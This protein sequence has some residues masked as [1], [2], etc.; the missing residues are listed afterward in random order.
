MTFGA[1]VLKEETR[2]IKA[3]FVARQI[4]GARNH[5]AVHIVFEAI[6]FVEMNR[7]LRPIIENRFFV[8]EAMLF[9]EFLSFLIAND[10][11]L[12]LVIAFDDRFHLMIDAEEHCGGGGASRRQQMDADA[13]RDVIGK[14]DFHIWI[15][16]SESHREDVTEGGLVYFHRVSVL[17]I[18]KLDIRIVIYFVIQLPDAVID[19][20]AEVFLLI[21]FV[22]QREQA[23]SFLT[24]FFLAVYFQ[25]E[26]H[27]FRLLM[28]ICNVSIISLF[29]Q[30]LPTLVRR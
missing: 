18:E 25:C 19:L 24:A 28:G 4:T 30:A 23:D 13:A 27:D 12:E 7:F 21:F 22:Q 6:A 14:T 16:S 26:W 2:G 15:G 9:I 8:A 29:L 17:Q 20:R 11:A 10:D 5:M 1:W 3:Q